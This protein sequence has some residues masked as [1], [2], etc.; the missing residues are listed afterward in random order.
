MRPDFRHMESGKRTKI[1]CFHVTPYLT[2]HSAFDAHMLL[3]EGGDKRVLYSGDFRIH[4]RK[5]S[6]VRKLMS[7]PPANVDV[8]LLEGTNLGSD[9]PTKSEHEI[10]NDFSSAVSRD[11]RPRFC[12]VVCPKCR[13]HGLTLSGRQACWANPRG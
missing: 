1:G 11:G 3:I 4:G 7:F 2:D 8:L 6:L 10:E 5:S 13:S 9:K 12:G